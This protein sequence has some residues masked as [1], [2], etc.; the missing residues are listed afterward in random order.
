MVTDKNSL[1]I[2]SRFVR[3]FNRGRELR[4]CLV[5]KP[6]VTWWLQF[7]RRTPKTPFPR[8]R[9]PLRAGPDGGLGIGTLDAAPKPQ[10]LPALAT[11]GRARRRAS[12]GNRSGARSI[13]DW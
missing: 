6:A 5:G 11:R 3:R 10:R 4:E 7:S 9:A 1:A 8:A 12:E 2:A 13:A